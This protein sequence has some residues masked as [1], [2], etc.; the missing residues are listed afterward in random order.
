MLM[1]ADRFEDAHRRFG[2]AFACLHGSDLDAPCVTVSTAFPIDP[3]LEHAWLA[4][5]RPSPASLHVIVCQ[6]GP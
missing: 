6:A 3:G 2:D 4:V 1:S 5:V